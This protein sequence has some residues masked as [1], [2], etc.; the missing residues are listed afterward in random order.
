MS[1]CRDA[2]T[3]MRLIAL[4]KMESSQPG[5]YVL[6]APWR[7]GVWRNESW[8]T[9]VECLIDRRFSPVEGRRRGSPTFL[10]ASA[11][12]GYK[13][14][15]PVATDGSRPTATEYTSPHAFSQ[16]LDRVVVAIRA[17]V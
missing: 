5:S 15:L 17:P 6:R 16:T 14:A 1:A 12:R 4:W 2:R 13:G 11:S 8:Q 10:R 9:D 7:K 3:S